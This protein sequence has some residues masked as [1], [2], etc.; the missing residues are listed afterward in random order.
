MKITAGTTG[1]I[2][3]IFI[4][5]SSST[6]GAGLAGLVYNTA[7]LTAKYKRQGSATWT[8]IS[9]ATA[10][11]GTWA[12]G[13]FVAATNADAG[14]YELH[15]PDLAIASGVAWV[16]VSLQGAANMAPIKIRLG[17]TATDDQ[18]ATDG[19]IT[20]ISTIETST[21][22]TIPAL[23]NA[24]GANSIGTVTRATDDQT[25]L[26][27]V[28]PTTSAATALGTNS[29]VSIDNGATFVAI[30]GTIT[31]LGLID[32]KYW[33]QIAFNAADRPTAQGA[34]WFRMLDGTYTKFFNLTIPSTAID[35]TSQIILADTNEL[36]SNQ[37]DW[38][39]AT[40]FSTHSASD[41]YTEF[42]DGSNLTTLSTAT[43]FATV[44]PDNTGIAAIQTKTDQI[45]FTVAN[46]V[47]SNA[48]SG[49][50]SGGSGAT[51]AEVRIEMDANS[52]K[53]NSIV[54]DTSELQNNQGNWLT[55][56][57]FSTHTI[58]EVMNGIKGAEVAVPKTPKTLDM[59]LISGDTFSQLVSDLGSL[60][61][62][63]VD[64]ILFSIKPN[65]SLSD[66]DSILLI[67]SESGLLR[68]NRSIAT[69]IGNAS[70]SIEDEATGIIIIAIE[71]NETV[72]IKH[73]TYYYSLKVLKSGNDTTLI[74]SGTLSVHRGGIDKTS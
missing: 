51:A 32:G 72:K 11:A 15:L 70:I 64:E 67:S 44:N 24:L 54:D 16:A 27:F 59:Q 73:G 13:G 31:E 30:T 69:N 10:T 49:G 52:S 53:L 42:G 56:T 33:Y 7:S 61:S 29:L 28:W 19:G 25:P 6:V 66:D 50:G 38:L 37:G 74:R 55:A 17:L 26:S 57:G 1:Y 60:S 22:I 35:A 2:L 41:V 62:A 46:Q 5:D 4:Q 58:T 23:I 9:L 34:S 14:D 47:D 36:Q 12:S 40:G 71:S 65:Q 68:I 3:D 48:L 43:G 18:S 21:M 8:T 20:K 45:V 63:N 39:T